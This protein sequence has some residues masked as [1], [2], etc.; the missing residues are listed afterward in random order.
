MYL[1]IGSLIESCHHLII[2]VSAHSLPEGTFFFGYSP[3][4]WFAEFSLFSFL[5]SIL[6][7]GNTH[8]PIPVLL[9]LD[10]IGS[11]Q[12]LYFIYQSNSVLPKVFRK[13]I[14]EEVEHV[15]YVAFIA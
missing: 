5:A 10:K 11:C 13:H 1:F 9:Q 7:L 12:S 4:V 8:S 2:G 15:C 14:L 6:L 3:F